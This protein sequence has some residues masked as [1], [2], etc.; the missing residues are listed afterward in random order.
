[1]S[2][3]FTPQHKAQKD[4][5]ILKRIDE[6]LSRQGLPSA[7]LHFVVFLLLEWQWLS[8]G[9]TP[10]AS[11]VFGLALVIMAAWRFIM[12]A[13]FSD[14]YARG[15]ARWRDTFI[16]SGF[17]H[18]GVW[19]AYL[20]Y[21]LDGPEHPIALLGLLYTLSVAAGGTFVYSLYGRTVRVYLAVLLLPMGLF[22]LFRSDTAGHLWIG[23]AF[24]AVYFY[25]VSTA[26][27]VSELVWSFLTHNHE[28]KMRLKALEEAREENV[29]QATTN[30]R[31]VNQLLHRVKTPLS[32]L[33]GVLGM[34]SHDEQST[35]H[36]G[37]LN[38]ARRSGRSILDL[39][40][41]LEAFIEQRDQSRVPQSIVFNLR[42]T[43]EHA[44]SDMGSKA[45]EHGLELAYLYHPS[46]PERIEL[47]PQWLSNAFRRL[48]DFTLDSAE[49]GEI[50]VR[51]AM[52]SASEQEQDHLLLSFYFI[53]TEVSD[54]DLRAAIN[55]NMNT[56]PEDEDVSDQLTLMVAA[57]QFKSMNAKLTV[58][59]KQDL[60]KIVVSL[61]IQASSQQASSFRPAKYMAGR[62]ITL[63]DLSPVTERALSAEFYS[64]DMTVSTWTMERLL[65]GELI[66]PTDFILINLPVE[67][68]RA[69]S[70]LEQVK[71]L[72]SR[73][74]TQAPQTTVFL[75]ASQ[76][77]RGLLADMDLGFRFIEKPATRDELL[78]MLRQSHDATRV[79]A[80]AEY[81]CDHVRVLLAEDNMVNQK[82]V[83]RLLKR[84]GAQVDTCVNGLEASQQAIQDPPYNLVIMDC[85]MPRMDGLEATRIIRHKEMDTGTHLPIIALTGEDTPEQE[86]ACLA[87]GMDDFMTKPVTYENLITLIQRWV[88]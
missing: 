55:R 18:A 34:L 52:E 50:T 83:V 43:L 82:V 25:L 28:L 24:I 16:L 71:L 15:P 86:R 64:W 33:L 42:K 3:F 54:E 49:E 72:Q 75:Y 56:L 48:L 87:A 23:L 74:Q 59:S 45:H 38:I 39:V 13:Q 14:W 12:I 30:R 63:V 62:S 6:T 32:G 70:Y 53:N 68:A 44:L 47:D 31:F 10:N 78:Q 46:V 77:Q 58:S 51:I 79:D 19:T 80:S 11:Y 73:L 40:T 76:L 81:R 9:P 60:R 35:E 57:A 65:D 1:M 69:Q 84:M 8:V 37:M 4:R 36:Q 67:D 7:V 85:L 21:R 29:L 61:P 20:V 26:G 17:L 5:A 66:Q 88:G 41:D 27:R 2:W 22:Y